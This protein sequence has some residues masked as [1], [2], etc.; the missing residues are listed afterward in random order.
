MVTSGVGKEDFQL[1]LNAHMLLNVVVG[2]IVAFR[3]LKG[4]FVLLSHGLDVSV[5]LNTVIRR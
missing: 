5:T 4:A 2:L 3:L 1:P